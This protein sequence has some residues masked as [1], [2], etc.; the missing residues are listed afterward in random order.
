MFAS[1]GMKDKLFNAVDI[2]PN[3]VAFS[4]KFLYNVTGEVHDCRK[5]HIT[6]PSGLE[7]I[8]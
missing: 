6:L 2:H 5:P 4:I 1:S 7:L 3:I 8:V